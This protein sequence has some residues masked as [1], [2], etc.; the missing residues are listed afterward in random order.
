MHIAQV[1]ERRFME[2]PTEANQLISDASSNKDAESNVALGCRVVENLR[3]GTT[4]ILL[5]RLGDAHVLGC[6]TT[7]R[8]RAER[9]WIGECYIRV[10]AAECRPAWQQ[11]RYGG[12][13]FGS[14]ECIYTRI[15]VARLAGLAEKKMVWRDHNE[16]EAARGETSMICPARETTG[17][18]P[19][20]AG[21]SHLPL[22]L[23]A[24]GR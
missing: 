16:H 5:S 6:V 22:M 21:H 17:A 2:S 20:P 8:S 12:C 1:A 4:H 3:H 14:C 10:A 9:A 24:Q 13:L 23:A 11:A 18:R 7:S 15:A 19:W